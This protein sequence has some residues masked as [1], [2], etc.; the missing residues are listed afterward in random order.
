MKTQAFYALQLFVMILRD[1][2]VKL[3]LQVVKHPEFEKNPFAA[4]KTHIQEEL[5][6]KKKS[7][8]TQVLPSPA[9]ASDTTKMEM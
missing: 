1:V 6:M 4:L 2:Q 3:Y 5:A 9:E 7:R 8:E